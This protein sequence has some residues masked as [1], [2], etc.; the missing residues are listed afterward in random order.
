MKTNGS[1]AR[2]ER[3]IYLLMILKLTVHGF[4]GSVGHNIFSSGS[5]VASIVATEG[6]V[7]VVKRDQPAARR[8]HSGA[9]W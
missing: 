2:P 7:G 4:V 1:T 6:N 5:I 8:I 3:Q 9:P